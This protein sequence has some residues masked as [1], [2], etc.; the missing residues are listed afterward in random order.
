MKSFLLIALIS[1]SFS[2]HSVETKIFGSTYLSSSHTKYGDKIDKKIKFSDFSKLG[3]NAYS[4]LSER[5][6]FHGQVLAKG[7]QLTDS[8][9][10]FIDYSFLKISI[11]KYLELTIGRQIFP[12]WIDSEY[13]D[14]GY[15]TPY[16]QTHPSILAISPIKSLNGVS[17][18]LRLTNTFKLRPFIGEESGRVI[19]SKDQNEVTIE[20]SDI[21]G[22]QLSWEPS[23]DYKF[24][25]AMYKAKISSDVPDGDYLFEDNVNPVDSKFLSISTSFDNEEFV[26]MAEYGQNTGRQME[27]KRYEQKGGYVLAGHYFGRLLPRYTFSYFYADKKTTSKVKVL[28]H[29]VGVNFD[30]EN[31]CIFKLDIQNTV[32]KSSNINRFYKVILG[33]DF[34][35]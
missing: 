35:L 5:V 14:V 8:W 16:I 23:V 34:V 27:G 7:M 12:T 2:V 1:L 30:F 20:I 33:V 4:T 31:S 28:E 3:I 9:A 18:N 10:V 19:T 24:Q 32:V 13:R 29:S 26:G 17:V 21:R 25:L 11:N 15:E 6:H 22:F